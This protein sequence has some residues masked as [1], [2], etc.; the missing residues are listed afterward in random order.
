MLKFF[1]RIRQKLID[2][3]NL[4]RYLIYAV[5]EILLVVIGILIALQINNL[6]EQRKDKNKEGHFIKMILSD[7]DGSIE[8]L[9]HSVWGA[10]R[11][12]QGG[13]LI[14]NELGHS[15]ENEEVDSS[16]FKP[17]FETLSDLS[18]SIRYLSITRTFES[19]HSAYD[20]LIASGNID[21]IK[22]PV[23]RTKIAL[24]YKELGDREGVN[25]FFLAHTERYIQALQDVG[26][27]L[28]EELPDT[29]IK[30][31]LMDSPAVLAAIKNQMVSAQRQI[32]E[33]TSI[34]NL[35]TTFRNE[36]LSNY[37]N[38]SQD[39]PKTNEEL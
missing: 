32:N 30:Q 2:E 19:S 7:M 28:K 15:E 1:R 23:V 21:V 5:G 4:K 33:C 17:L 39:N 37:S 11:Q 12:I 6:N 8:D 22:D 20:E 18:S 31:R 36:L 25:Q 14:L 26:I 34:M 13:K 38:L 29:I 24:L 3:G 9:E 27:S 35:I 16:F 10:N